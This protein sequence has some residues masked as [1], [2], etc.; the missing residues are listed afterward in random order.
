MRLEN[1]VNDWPFLDHS[2]LKKGMEPAAW[3]A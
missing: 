1:M 2:S 3:L